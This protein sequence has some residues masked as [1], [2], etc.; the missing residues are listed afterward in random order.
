MKQTKKNCERLI[1]LLYICYCKVFLIDRVY[2]NGLNVQKNSLKNNDMTAIKLI[3]ALWS[4]WL[5]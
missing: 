1:I 3:P 5:I 4:W 2:K